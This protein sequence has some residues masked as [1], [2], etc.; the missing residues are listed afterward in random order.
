MG[1]MRKSTKVTLLLVTVVLCVWSTNSYAVSSL[2]GDIDGFGFGAAPGMFGADGN[3]AER[4]GPL[5]VLDPGDVL[6]DINRSGKVR[7]TDGDDFDKRSAAEAAGM[8][9]KWTDVSLSNSFI[10]K[11]GSADDVSFV[12]NFTVPS[13]GDPDHGLPHYISFVYG[14]YDVKPMTA[15]VEG[16]TVTLTDR[17]GHLDGFIS[18]AYAPIAWN[19]MTD[20][21]V[22]IDLVA[23]NEPYVAFDYALL[24]LKPIETIP[25]PG[26]I[27]L[28]GIGVA[29]VGWF[30]RHREM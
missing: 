11:P 17:P 26:G 8:Y 13:A 15:V 20:G 23:A 6:P 2:I 5:N 22:T 30:R 7:S 14:D 12:F 1:K 16:D 25:A 10:G 19:D 29:F 18:S 24:D 28:A 4:S 21:V 3:P 27:L 9:T